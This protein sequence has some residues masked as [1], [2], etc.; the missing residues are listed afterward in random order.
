MTIDTG[1]N[2]VSV[3]ESFMT[4]AANGPIVKTGTGTLNAPA[5]SIAPVKVQQG[6]LHVSD[7]ALPEFADYLGE[8]ALL[9]RWSFNGDVRDSVGGTSGTLVG[10]TSWN[11]DTNPGAIDLPGGTYGTSC[12]NLGTGLLP[13]DGSAITIEIWGTVH[14]GQ[15]YSRVFSIGTGRA[16]QFTITWCAGYD[17]TKIV[18]YLVK[19]S[20]ILSKTVTTGELKERRLHVVMTAIPQAD[21]K[22][23]VSWILRDVDTWAQLANGS[24]TTT[25]A[26]T[27]SDFASGEML[28]GRSHDTLDGDASAT[29]DEVRIW[30]G[31][32]PAA[33]LE[34][35]AKLGPDLLPLVPTERRYSTVEVSAGATFSVGLNS[36]TAETVRGTGTLAGEGTLTVET[37][38]VAGDEI[39]TLTA[40]GSLVVKNWLLDVESGA[41]CDKIEG[42]GTLDVSNLLLSV[43]DPGKLMGVYKLAEVGSIAGTPKRVEGLK[44][45]H[46]VSDGQRMVLS[47]EGMMIFVR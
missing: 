17:T 37:L 34:R 4:I 43:R 22:S 41:V 12:V 35:S 28:L 8:D 39:G 19:G 33:Q 25:A 5:A 1:D 26:W 11:D 2:T 44:G 14:A 20:T 24:A 10:A 47:R 45:W 27:P 3:G 36:V 9:H 46:L 18:P 16:N 7:D 23:L 6:V 42:A 15:N 38:D 32:V 13:T 29:Y 40:N 21:G 30:K 31:I